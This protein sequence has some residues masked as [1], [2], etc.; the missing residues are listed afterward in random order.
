MNIAHVKEEALQSEVKRLGLMLSDASD[1]G[2]L[3]SLQCELKAAHDEIAKMR[4]ESS[5][6]KD[7]LRRTRAQLQTSDDKS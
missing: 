7:D 4:G 6:L 5:V 1:H 3:N 2:V